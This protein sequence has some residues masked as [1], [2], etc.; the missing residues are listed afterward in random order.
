M[1]WVVTHL[2]L[3]LIVISFVQAHI[4]Q[5]LRQ[6]YMFALSTNMRYRSIVFWLSSCFDYQE[7]RLW[8]G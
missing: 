5:V 4:T 8:L 7:V 6:Y 1:G 3:Y 2:T